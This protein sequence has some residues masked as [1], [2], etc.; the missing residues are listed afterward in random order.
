MKDDPRFFRARAALEQF[1]Q[2]AQLKSTA[3]IHPTYGYWQLPDLVWRFAEPH[4]ELRELFASIALTAP[5]NTEWTFHERKNSF[6]LPL[7]LANA[8]TGPNGEG[9]Q[10][11]RRLIVQT[12]QAFCEEANKDMDLIIQGIAEAGRR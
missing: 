5:K 9:M 3:A 7:R 8:S 6:I 12:D 10:E 1:A 4:D 11:A 2:V